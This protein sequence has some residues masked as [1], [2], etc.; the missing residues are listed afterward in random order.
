MK[1]T[2]LGAARQVTGSKYLIEHGDKKILVDCGLL[3]GRSDFTKGNWDKLP[4]D[5]GKIDAV[6]LT[7]AHIDHTGYIPKL[8]KDGFK[9]KVYCSKGTFSLSAIMLADSGYL[10]EMEAKEI[11]G[12]P[13]Y[14]KEDAE[15][16][17]QLFQIVDFD[18]TFSI[19]SLS[20]T[21]IC[22]GHILGASFVIV[23]DGK[24]T[25]TFSGDLGRPNQ[26]LMKAPPHIKKTDYLVLES[27]YGDR[28]HEKSDP[29]KKVGEIVNHTVAKGGVLILPS[30]AVGRSQAL[31]YCLYQLKQSKIIPDIPIFLD[32]PMAIKVTELFCQYGDEHKLPAHSCEKIFNV[33]SYTRRVE[34]SKKLDHLKRPAIIIAGSGM[35]DGGRIVHHF[36]H[37]ISDSKNTIC[38]VGFQPEGT[39]GYKLTRDAKK[40]QIHGRTYAVNAEIKTID[41]FSAHADYNEILEWLGGFEVVPQKIFL[42]HGQLKSAESLKEKIEDRFKISVLIPEYGDSFELI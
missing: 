14:T 15:L 20:I 24:K 28:L 23:S 21:L 10:Q 19:G 29:I 5:P 34:E 41:S 7:H 8:V 40:L 25:L 16:S 27:T 32:S 9:G 35:G 3:Q 4:L 11:G 6:I 42:T 1:I 13:L 17:L 36:K 12:Q 31:L 33:A 2:F 22:S 30:F 18:T 26:T 38:F 37:F 39:N